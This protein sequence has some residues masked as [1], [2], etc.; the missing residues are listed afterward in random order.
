MQKTYVPALRLCLAHQGEDTAEA[1]G[2]AVFDTLNNVEDVFLP[3]GPPP[4]GV[5]RIRPTVKVYGS[6]VA[7]LEDQKFAVVATYGPCFDHTPCPQVGGCYAGPGDVVPGGPPPP[8]CPGQDY[9]SEEL[10]P[11]DEP[12][13]SCDPPNGNVTPADPVIVKPFDP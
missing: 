10:L 7:T 2:G 3:L 4:V 13:P 1:T 11:E 6:S 5:N 9:S 8:G 12:F